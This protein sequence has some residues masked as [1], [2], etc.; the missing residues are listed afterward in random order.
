MCGVRVDVVRRRISDGGKFHPADRRS[1]FPAG[2]Q[3]GATIETICYS[4]HMDFLWTPWRYAYVTG[5]HP[6][7]GCIFCDAVRQNEDPKTG[8]VLRAK[9]CFVILNT[10]PYTSGHVMIVPYDHL[11]ELR[12]LEGSAAEEMMVLA[13]RLEDALRE[14]Y[15]PDGI[16]LGMNIGRAAG[17]GVAG[18]VHLHVLPRWSADTNFMTTVSETRIL[19]E[20]LEVTYQRL[21]QKLG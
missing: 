21:K 15:R 18:H 3:A 17:A 12:K 10:F 2:E 20:S 13:Q 11:D 16:N 14:I 6:S 5:A 9:R 1:H 7:T 8:I 19:P 4:P